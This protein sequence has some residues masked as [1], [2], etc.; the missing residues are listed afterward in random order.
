MESDT[1]PKTVL[2]HDTFCWACHI[3]GPVV[4]CKQCPR[5]FHQRCVTLQSPIPSKWVCTECISVQNAEKNP[6]ISADQLP[7]MLTFAID[8]VKSVADSQPFFKPVDTEQ[9][10][11]YRNYVVCPIDIGNLEERI[12]QKV[13][14]SSRA[15]LADF[16]WI[17]HNCIVFNSFHSKLTSTART[18][19][20]AIKLCFHLLMLVDPN[21]KLCIYSGVQA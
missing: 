15:F 19:M 11:Q 9:F 7:E 3:D 14:S 10:P 12:A 18:M 13:Y 2:Q 20:K 5:V 21:Y 1:K 16:R 6:R 8:R 4:E 17:L